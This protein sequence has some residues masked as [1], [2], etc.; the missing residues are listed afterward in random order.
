M[1]GDN[2][3]PEDH[4]AIQ[5]NYAPNKDPEE[6]RRSREREIEFRKRIADDATRDAVN[7]QR[8]ISGVVTHVKRFENGD[9]QF[10]FIRPDNS[11]LHDIFIHPDE[12]EPWRTGFKDLETG[13]KVLFKVDFGRE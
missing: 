5:R 7:T 4:A 9:M 1:V 8:P 3:K 13:Q 2:A 11:S 12:I 10:G 6:I